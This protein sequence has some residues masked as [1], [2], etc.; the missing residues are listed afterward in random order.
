MIRLK[1]TAYSSTANFL[2]AAGEIA[3]YYGFEHFQDLQKE[4]SALRPLPPGAKADTDIVFARKDEKNLPSA[5]KRLAQCIHPGVATLAW[6]AV[7][8]QNGQGVSLELHVTGIPTSI[9]EAILIAAANAITKEAGISNRALVLNNM[10]GLESSSRFMRDVGVYLRKHIDTIAAS[11]QPRAATD[12]LGTLV[13]LIERG[14][15]G[16]S[17]APQPMDYLTEDERRRFWDLLEY[18][19]MF[20]VP[21]ELSG[22]ILGSRDLWAHTL[23]ELLGDDPITGERLTVAFGGRYDP[24]ISRF[25]RRHHTAAMV[26]IQIESRGS[27]EIKRRHRGVRSIYFAHLGP[28]ARRR[29]LPLIELLRQQGIPVY[30]GLWHERIGEQMATAISLATPFILV[31]GHK[32]AMEGTVMVREVATNSQDAVPLPELGGFLKRKRVGQPVKA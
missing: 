28:E 31:M 8:Q 29:A 3:E 1:G 14:H 16:V 6:R 30:H 9:A 25:A 5:A 26:S 17:R 19:E 18:I 11:L 27:T 4:K 12:P 22:Q 15:P 20:G 21:Y 13:Q 32:E 23:F 24:L 7:P 10:G 2:A